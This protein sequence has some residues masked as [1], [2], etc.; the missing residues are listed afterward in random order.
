MRRAMKIVLRQINTRRYYA[1][2]Q[3]WT[4]DVRGA[5]D[6]GEVER[7]IKASREEKLTGMEVVLSF[8]DG[9]DDPVLRFPLDQ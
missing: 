8:D 7:A 3:K 4:T 2:P 5:I 9:G 1:G 6:F